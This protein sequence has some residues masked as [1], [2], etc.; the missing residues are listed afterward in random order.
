[1]RVSYHDIYACLAKAHI[2]VRQKYAYT[3]VQKTH[4][5]ALKVSSEKYTLDRAHVSRTH[6]ETNGQPYMY[7]LSF[8]SA[9]V[10]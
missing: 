6:F 4:I 1:M 2:Y 10:V 3:R 9:S 7:M 5:Y 8:S